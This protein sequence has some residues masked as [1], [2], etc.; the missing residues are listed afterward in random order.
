MMK[1]LI[2]HIYNTLNYGSAMMAINLIYGLRERLDQNVEIFCDCDDYHLQRLKLATNDQ[3]LKSFIIEKSPVKSNILKG[4]NLILGKSPLVKMVSNKFQ[5]M[6]VLG[7]DDL[8]ETNMKSAIVYGLQYSQINRSCDVILAGQSIGPFKGIYKWL[9]K[10]VFK[11]L[12]I[13]TRD[14]NSFDFCKNNLN[15]STI[16]QSRDLALHSLPLQ[17]KWN[18]ISE[19]IPLVE[20]SYVVL[21]PS[22]LVS[23]YTTDKQ[24]YIETWTALINQILNRDNVDNILILAH[25]L[26][27]KGSSDVS[28][29]EDIILQIPDKVKSRIITYINPIQPAEARALLGR[30]RYVITGRMHAAVS[31]C[32]MGKPAISLAYSEKYMGVISRGLDIGKLVIDCRNRQWGSKSTI[33]HDIDQI[34]DF[35][36]VNYE[37]M[38]SKVTIRATE[39]HKMVEDQINLIASF[40]NH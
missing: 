2:A 35:V 3:N 21:V 33:L 39:C 23:K 6:I 11:N 19:T 7:G 12:T 10:F 4:I 36:D 14:D 38:C 26:F 13:I 9:A 25:V 5:I 27:P 32:F 30:A 22:G 17:E 24:G 18:L 40:V 20:S 29:I 8:A 37:V 28:I 34:L 16:H 31:T 15:L 1:I